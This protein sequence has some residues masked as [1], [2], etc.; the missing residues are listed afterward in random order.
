MQ[1]LFFI[2]LALI[3]AILGFNN[4]DYYLILLLSIFKDPLLLYIKGHKKNGSIEFIRSSVFIYVLQVIVFTIF[5]W[6]GKAFN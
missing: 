2:I 1:L 4:Y 5:Y 3:S 6:I